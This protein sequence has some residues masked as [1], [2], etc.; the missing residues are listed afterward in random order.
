MRLH[1]GEFRFD[2][3]RR[4]LTR[5]GSAVHLTPKALQLLVFLLENRPRVVSKKEIYDVLWPG[6]FVEESNLSVLI[7]EIRSALDDDPKRPRFIKTAH[8]FGYGFVGEAWED[9][10][11]ETAVIRL[12]FGSRE[13]ELPE[14]E[15]IVGR[16]PEA[17]ILLNSP[18][19]S[20]RH[21][22]ITVR[23]TTATIEDLGSKN[24]TYVQGVRLTDAREL[25]D[26]DEIRVCRELL[27]VVMADPSSST[28]TEIA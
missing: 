27:T 18:G 24:G 20:R 15:H 13:V 11:P 22:R 3:D 7:S 17:R 21:A 10:S 28:I 26:G 16:D 5:R 14:G 2:G 8:G 9:G 4:E 25:K 1:F 12:R 19:I 23:G 6:V